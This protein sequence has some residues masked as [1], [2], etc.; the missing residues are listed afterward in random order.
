M[1]YDFLESVGWTLIC[2]AA[3]LGLYTFI[4]YPLLLR[5]LAKVWGIEPVGR[6]GEGQDEDLP[7]VSVTVPAYNEDAQI[8]ST[9]ESLLNLDYPRDRLQILIVSDGSTDRTDEIVHSYADRGVELLR[10]NERRGKTHAESV[11]AKVLTGEFIVNT[12]ASIRLDPGAIRALI[13]HFQDPTVG[14]ASGRDVSLGEVE[15]QAGAGESSYVGFEMRLRA[16]ETRFGGIVGASGSLYAVRRELH[17]VDLPEGLSRDFAAALVSIKCGYRAVSVDEA[18]CAVPVTSSLRREYARK[19]RTI[20]RGMVTLWYMR[21]ILNPLRYGRFAWM[22]FSHKVCRWLISVA[23][24]L[25]GLGLVLLSPRHPVAAVFTGG[26]V[27]LVALGLIGWR[28]PQNRPMPRWISMPSFA[29]ITTTAVLHA[30]LRAMQ[31]S[32]DPIWEPTRRK[33]PAE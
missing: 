33:V 9:I 16:L 4:G 2:V 17:G 18:I 14:L 21:G 5:L 7:Y 12:D 25:G 8:A 3:S 24:V 23:V 27:G 22:L 32:Q 26:G 1:S 10:V 30:W 28:W 31:G 6:L 29:L 11:A 20:T 19:V 15:K 13:P